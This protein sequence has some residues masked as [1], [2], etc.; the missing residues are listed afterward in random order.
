[1]ARRILTVSH[2]YPSPAF[3]GLG[4]FVQDEVVELARRNH[5]SVVAPLRGSG[6]EVRRVPTETEEEG[7]RV[8]RPRFP[9]IPVGGRVIEPRLWAHRLCPLLRSLYEE[10]DADLVHAHFA[11]PDGFAAA[12]FAARESVPLV[13]TIRG[14]DVL[15]LGRRWIARGDLRHTLEQT[16]A[17]I[18]VSDELA[19]YATR[20]GVPGGRIHV[21]P[22]GVPYRPREGRQEARRRLGVDENAI[23]VLWVGRLVSVKAPLEAIRAFA[24]VVDS[25]APHDAVLVM[26][27]E[28]PLTARASEL[29]RREGLDGRVRLLGYQSRESVWTWQCASD[30]QINSS[31]S[32]G[33]PVAVL[34]ALGAGTPVA[35]YPLPGVRAALTAVDGG[36]TARESTPQALAAA[37]SQELDAA[38]DRDSLADEARKRFD[39]A[40]TGREIEDV[41]ASVL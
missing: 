36:T 23:C 16:R 25:S 17:L 7:I 4:T 9:G 24:R 5:L 41:Y 22:G 1:M 35:A 37:I 38:R 30:V 39:I 8:V 14:S 3:P 2:L 27:G 11:L 21:I 10:M 31:R 20:L 13:L 34:E 6:A 12:N 40:G 33:T 18:A 29:V 15:V 26:L 32:E 28:G 19:E